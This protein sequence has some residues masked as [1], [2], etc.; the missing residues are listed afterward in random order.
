MYRKL[1]FRPLIRAE[2]G[3][4]ATAQCNDQCMGE[5]CGFQAWCGRWGGGADYDK[6]GWRMLSALTG[7]AFECTGRITPGTA[8][9]S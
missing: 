1:G 6:E 4:G 3:F 7:E 2:R 9:S 8:T 5:T